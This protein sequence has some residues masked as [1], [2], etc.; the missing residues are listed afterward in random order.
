MKRK[1]IS[2]VEFVDRVI[3]RNEADEPFSL[4]DHQ[5]V[6]LS[7]A[8]DHLSVCNVFVY[9]TIKK[10]GKT[11][12]Q[13]L[14]HLWWSLVH[15]N[16]EVLLLAN[17]KEQSVGRVFKVMCGIVRYNEALRRE[18]VLYTDKIVFSNG[19]VVQAI[20]NDAPSAAGANM[21]ATG[22][23][24][25]HGYTSERS[26]RLWEELTPLAN[27]PS[28]RVVST[29]AGWENESTLL[30]N[31]YLAGVGPEEHPQGQAERIHPELP[32]Y[33]NKSAGILCLWDHVGR[34]PWQ[35]SADY[36]A[37]Q[38]RG[39]RPS[40]YLRL[41]ENR[42]T[43]SESVFLTAEQYDACVEFGLRQ[44]L[45][46]I[47]YAGIDCG[48]KSDCTSVV[49]IKHDQHSDR[50]ILAGCKVWQPVPGQTLDLA[51]TLELFLLQLSQRAIIA[52]CLYDPSQMMRTA[53]LLR[54]SGIECEELS[55]TEG[56][57]SEATSTLYDAFINQRLRLYVDE[58]LRSHCL[59]ASTKENERIFR[60]RKQ[61]QSKKI[62]A[63][64]AL[65]FAVL[66]ATRAGRPALMPEFAS[67]YKIECNLDPD[68]PLL[69]E[70]QRPYDGPGNAIRAR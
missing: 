46:G 56:H 69:D 26:M 6:F 67:S 4:A 65:S 68:F 1:S 12:L 41:H 23:D 47:L 39:L 53:A 18:A 45:S 10:S 52:G 40:S 57:L 2:P 43:S 32:I 35:Q 49:L 48:L 58:T 34:M 31:L 21:G 24:E 70:P 62:D 19:T 59:G 60:L 15:K 27:K 61:Q 17:D 13:A 38:K 50:L 36:F 14:W 7:L 20:S 28:V 42:W 9:S 54:E 11:T 22:W 5:R 16:D 25:L 44:D 37:K 64:V 8:F 63:A 55:Q 3:K 51:N 30:W 33:L 29:Y 66:C